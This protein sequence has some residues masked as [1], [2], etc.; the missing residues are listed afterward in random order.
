[1]S[2]GAVQGQSRVVPIV[3][4][5]VG[6]AGLIVAALI[7]S[8]AFGNDDDVPPVTPNPSEPATTTS[9]Q[10]P[11]I[12]GPYYLDPGNPRIILVEDRGNDSYAVAS[13]HDPWRGT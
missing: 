10:A 1:M 3:V 11:E 8:G 12:G 6:A 9:E 5:L 2:K 13:Q 4:A 7:A